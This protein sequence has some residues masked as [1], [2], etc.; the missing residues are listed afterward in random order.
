MNKKKIYTAPFHVISFKW[1]SSTISTCHLVLNVWMKLPLHWSILD[2]RFS[3]LKKKLD[4][5]FLKP[6]MKNFKIWLLSLKKHL[7][8][9][10]TLVTF[11]ATISIL[12]LPKGDG[13]SGTGKLILSRKRRAF[14]LEITAERGLWFRLIMYF[15]SSFV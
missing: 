8:M 12:C 15:K 6:L 1:R 7:L 14:P 4:G 10:W 13:S 3:E 2:N 5:K 9:L 11:T